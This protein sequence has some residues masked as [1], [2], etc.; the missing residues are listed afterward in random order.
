MLELYQA[1][2]CPY[3]AKV[4]T[5]MTERGVSY[6]IHNPRTATPSDVRNEETHD[7]L[8]DL[9]E[10]DQLPFLVDTARG[11]RRYESEDIVEYVERHYP[12]VAP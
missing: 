11:E 2:D 4:R 3:C 6:V 7:A 8:L 1:E 5:A 10:R 12:G 9:G